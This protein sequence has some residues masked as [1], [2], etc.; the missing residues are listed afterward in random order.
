MGLDI[1]IQMSVSYG[2]VQNKHAYHFKRSKSPNAELLSN[3]D[4]SSQN[5][6]N[7]LDKKQKECRISCHLK[8][9]VALQFFYL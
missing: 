6:G 4:T 2:H 5:Q 3:C 8:T 7:P 9:I 1:Y